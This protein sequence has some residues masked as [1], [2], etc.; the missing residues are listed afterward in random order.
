M[1]DIDAYD[2]QK[3]K[4][5]EEME[6]LRP[7]LFFPES[8]NSEERAT[9]AEMV[10]PQKMRTAMFASIPMKCYAEKCRFAD[11]CPLMKENLAP[12]GKPCPIEMAAVQQYMSEYLV[13]LD[14]NPDNLIEVGMV[15][16]LVDQEIQYLR[17][18][19]VL[20]Q[21]DFIQE[22]PLGVDNKGNVVLRK[23]LH[24]AVELE[25][26]LHRRK[27]DLR[28]QLLATREARAKVGQGQLDTAQ[29]ISKVMD[30]IR[31]VETAKQKALQA[32]LG[33][34][35]KDDYIDGEVIEE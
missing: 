12:K 8:W 35:E 4:F 25:D 20:S 11:I 34:A 16:D 7:D 33:L 19:W 31:Q 9:A 10:R 14:V 13:E 32:K 5:F 23:E 28:N 1:S 30:Q 22:N 3:A 15:R 24:L 17:K 27:R 29:A 26:R 6:S 18:T 2:P 21:E